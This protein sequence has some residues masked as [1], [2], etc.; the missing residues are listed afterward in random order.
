[1]VN[2]K[3]IMLRVKRPE[4]IPEVPHYA[5]LLFSSES[6]YFPGDERSRTCPGHGYPEHTET[7]DII[8]YWVTTEIEILNNFVKSLDHENSRAYGAKKKYAVL[9]VNSKARV[10]HSISVNF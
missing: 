2:Q 6:V 7:F 3:N 5:I 9:R 4:D 8:E 10:E 1:M